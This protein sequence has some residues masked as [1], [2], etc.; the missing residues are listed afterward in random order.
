MTPEWQAMVLDLRLQG[1]AV[2]WFTPKELDES[3]VSM[4]RAEDWMAGALADIATYNK[5]GE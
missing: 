5:N 1:Y 4:D 2:W 3:G